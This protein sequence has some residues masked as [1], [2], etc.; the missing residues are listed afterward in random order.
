L[1]IDRERKLLA[2]VGVGVLDKLIPHTLTLK[3][4]EYLF[5][6]L[7][8]VHCCFFL[9]VMYKKHDEEKNL[10]QTQTRLIT[11]NSQRAKNLQMR[12]TFTKRE[13]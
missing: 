6:F 11:T 5:S 4:F 3:I 8:Y 1:F 7:S 2:R 9:F 12:L 13:D 10:L